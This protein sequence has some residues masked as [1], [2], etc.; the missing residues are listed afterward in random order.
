[1]TKTEA[2]EIRSAQLMGRAVRED[3]L[4]KACEVLARAAHPN[5]RPKFCLPRLPERQ[6]TYMN[7]IL[8]F[9]LGRAMSK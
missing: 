3:R 2:F 7:A 5:S 6:R 4:R 1:M 9:N 8:C